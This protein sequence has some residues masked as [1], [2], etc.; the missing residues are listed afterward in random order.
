MR[1]HKSPDSCAND[2]ERAQGCEADIAIAREFET[3]KITLAQRTVAGAPLSA[4]TDAQTI[5]HVAGGSPR[6]EI[7]EVS[8]DELSYDRSVSRSSTPIASLV[9]RAG[10]WP[11]KCG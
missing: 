1:E 8:C 3:H 5:Q 9:K 2:R 7:V 11:P 4:R 10:L 6:T